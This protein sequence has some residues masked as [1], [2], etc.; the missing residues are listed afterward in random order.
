MWP[1]CT[2]KRRCGGSASIGPY[3]LGKA[4]GQHPVA[5]A[6]FPAKQKTDKIV[7]VPTAIKINRHRREVPYDYLISF[8]VSVMANIVAYIV[9][10]RIDK[11]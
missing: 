6:K 7:P 9:T 4:A 5:A 1:S 3:T 11:H 2:T 10:K 8:A